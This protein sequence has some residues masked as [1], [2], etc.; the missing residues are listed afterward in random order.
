MDKVWKGVWEIRNLAP[1][2]LIEKFEEDYVFY[3]APEGHKLILSGVAIAPPTWTL[4]LKDFGWLREGGRKDRFFYRGFEKGRGQI[5]TDDE[6][7]IL[8]LREVP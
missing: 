7:P 2:H 1:K 8:E 5:V 4:D 3:S 6:E